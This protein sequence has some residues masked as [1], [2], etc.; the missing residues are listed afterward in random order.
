MKQITVKANQSLRDIALEHY[1]TLEAMGQIVALNEPVL[2]NDARALVAIGVDY[3]QDSS[4]YLDVALEPGLTI[5]V[6]NRSDII[7]K[8]IIREL[9]TE[10][11]KYENG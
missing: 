4:F 3:L 11:T 9:K 2:K 6:N 5:Q 8:N 1:G 7:D 10:Q